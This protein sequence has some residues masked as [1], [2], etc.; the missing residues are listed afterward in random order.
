MLGLTSPSILPFLSLIVAVTFLVV[1]CKASMAS[2]VNYLILE[3]LAEPFQITENHESKGGVITDIVKQLF[4]N[5]EHNIYSNVLPIRRMGTML[6]LVWITMQ[7]AHVAKGIKKI[8]LLF[9]N[10]GLNYHTINNLTNVI[11][12]ALVVLCHGKYVVYFP[13]WMTLFTND[14]KLL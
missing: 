12:Y 3:A 4:A 9:G 6:S 14:L 5:S 8:N 2:D 7:N 11:V 13:N 10:H 1:F